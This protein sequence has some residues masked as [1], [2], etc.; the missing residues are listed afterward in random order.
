MSHVSAISAYNWTFKERFKSQDVYKRFYEL[1]LRLND[2]SY[3]DAGVKLQDH[4]CH[5]LAEQHEEEVANWF[6]A[7][8]CG[9]T[10][11]QSK[12]VG[13]SATVGTDL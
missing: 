5:W 8:W 3:Q 12:G 7:W 2:C 10:A 1:V 11:G 13:F 6:S 9:A 4:L